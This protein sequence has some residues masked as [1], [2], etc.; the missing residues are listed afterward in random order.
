MPALRPLHLSTT[1][2]WITLPALASTVWFF[3]LTSFTPLCQWNVLGTHPWH[4]LCF[5]QLVQES[6]VKKILQMWCFN[7]LF[8]I[9]SNLIPWISTL[10]M[11]VN[12][13]VWLHRSREC[14]L[15]P[16]RPRQRE[17]RDLMFW[18]RAV[19][20]NL[21]QWWEFFYTVKYD[22]HRPHRAIECLKYS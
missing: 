19:Q 4:V 3:L 20:Y 5:N 2:L 9:K 14:P 6:L 1:P 15:G 11:L 16:S 7:L 21:L 12:P 22:S 18:S 8:N 13:L 10:N 17:G